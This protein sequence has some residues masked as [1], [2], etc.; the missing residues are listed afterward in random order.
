MHYRNSVYIF[1]YQWSCLGIL[2]RISEGLKVSNST[3]AQ[4]ITYMINCYMSPY[5]NLEAS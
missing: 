2:N 3:N 4:L 5:E 1:L